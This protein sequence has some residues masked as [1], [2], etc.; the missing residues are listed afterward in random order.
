MGSELGERIPV[1][2]L[3]EAE[4]NPLKSNPTPE[5]WTI[6]RV[7]RLIYWFDFETGWLGESWI[8]EIF[9]RKFYRQDK[10]KKGV[11]MMTFGANFTIRTW[12]V[13]ALGKIEFNQSG[14]RIAH[15][16]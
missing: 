2:R 12:K 4:K 15:L 13:T 10:P 11:E 3:E 7:L 6:S 9:L 5:I 8:L 16:L 1:F 14:R